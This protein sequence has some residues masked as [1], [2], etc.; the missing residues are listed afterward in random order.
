MQCVIKEP[1]ER[2]EELEIHCYKVPALD[3]KCNSVI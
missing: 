2:R 1:K 3:M